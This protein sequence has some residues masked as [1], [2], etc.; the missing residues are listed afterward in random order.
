ME[1]SVIHILEIPGKKSTYYDNLILSYLVITL[2][3][4]FCVWDV[5]L[6]LNAYILRRRQPNRTIMAPESKVPVL[7]MQIPVCKKKLGAKRKPLLSRL[8]IY[9]KVLLPAGI[10]VPDWSM[11]YLILVFQG[12]E[13]PKMSQILAL[14]AIDILPM[15][16]FI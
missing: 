6:S 16:S 14:F 1:K 15:I 5:P 7:D 2:Y 12:Q 3:T 4:L 8:W 13:H 10:Y 11:S 9:E